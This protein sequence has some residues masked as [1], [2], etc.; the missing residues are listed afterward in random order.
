MYIFNVVRK[1]VVDA[2]PA[3]PNK[4]PRI[5]SKTEEIALRWVKGGVIGVFADGLTNAPLVM[6]TRTLA[7]NAAKLPESRMRDIFYKLFREGFRGCYSGFPVV[8]AASFMGTGGYCVGSQMTRDFFGEGHLTNA[9]AGVGGQITGSVVAWTKGAVISEIQQAPDA[10][11]NPKFINKGPIQIALIILKESGPSGLYR[12]FGIQI[13]NFG[14][15]NSLGELFAGILKKQMSEREDVQE[16][17][18]MQK[19]GINTVSWTAAA[20]LTAPLGF[21]KLNVQLKG[22]SPEHFPDSSALQCIK[23]VL[24]NKGIKGIY[25]G[26]GARMLAIGPRAGVFFTLMPLGYDDLR[27][28]FNLKIPKQQ[29]AH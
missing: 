27:K 29:P 21:A 7:W 5:P 24:K 11:K 19:F 8:A 23:R 9:A 3:L 17:S 14:A 25:E 6:Y 4:E 2:P 18:L 1:A 26:T 16:L 15:V 20:G 28:L 12:G 10:I 13:L 22:M